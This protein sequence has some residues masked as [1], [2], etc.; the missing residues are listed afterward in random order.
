MTMNQL[1]AINRKRGTAA[2]VA[3]LLGAFAPIARLLT[4][5]APLAT[6]PRVGSHSS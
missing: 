3:A 6:V 4:P 5:T 2:L 1:A